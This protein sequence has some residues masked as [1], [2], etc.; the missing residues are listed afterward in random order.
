ML[1]AA[2]FPHKHVFTSEVTNAT[3]LGAALVLWKGL[4]ER[5]EPSFG[6]GLKP[7]PKDPSLVGLVSGL[8]PAKG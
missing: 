8:Y 1:I 5:F 7:V 3:S 2:H 6:L 4:N